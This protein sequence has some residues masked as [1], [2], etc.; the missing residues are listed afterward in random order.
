MFVK[1]PF[2]LQAGP[3]PI[4]PQHRWLYPIDWQQLTDMVRFERAKARCEHCQP[5]HGRI[6]CHLGDGRWWDVDSGI[7]CDD[8]GLAVRKERPPPLLDHVPTTRRLPRYS[9][10]A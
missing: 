4:R 5:P 8:R 6:V 1:R 10:P 2:S 9:Q 3:T 7:W